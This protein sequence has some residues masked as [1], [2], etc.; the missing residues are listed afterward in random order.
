LRGLT[1]RLVVVVFLPE[2]AERNCIRR[3][4]TVSTPWEGRNV[5][6]GG[7]PVRVIYRKDLSLVSPS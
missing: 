6:S 1:K 3:K 4:I 7:L 2:N 5:S